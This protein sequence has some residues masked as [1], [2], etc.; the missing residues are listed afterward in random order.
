MQSWRGACAAEKYPARGGIFAFKLIE[1][2]ARM[3]MS[4][5]RESRSIL[6]I[7]ARWRRRQYENEMA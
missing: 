2:I 6:K 3:S 7:K 4:A 5:M 1:S